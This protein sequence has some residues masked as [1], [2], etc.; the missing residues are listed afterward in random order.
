MS[1]L[2]RL[3]AVGILIV[4]GVLLSKS[5]LPSIG[6]T[7]NCDEFGHIH[8]YHMDKSTDSNHANL[9]VSKDDNC[10]AGK[11]I[12][13]FSFTA[14]QNVVVAVSFDQS[15]VII[16]YNDNSPKNPYIEPRK[17]PPRFS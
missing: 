8:L 14:A 10:H 13:S 4:F 5:L 6:D 9:K 1:S 12:F 3:I 7:N 17:K 15:S 11:N 2:K 16:P